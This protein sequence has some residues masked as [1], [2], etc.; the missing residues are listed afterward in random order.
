MHKQVCV[1]EVLFYSLLKF[2]ILYKHGTFGRIMNPE[3]VMYCEDNDDE[4]CL[5]V[6]KGYIAPQ[7]GRVKNKGK[8][9]RITKYFMEFYL[10]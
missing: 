6:P 9:Q 10:R 8:L 1:F 7:S 5:F 3:K 2:I 4:C